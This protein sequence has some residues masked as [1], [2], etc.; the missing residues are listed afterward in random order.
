MERF[1]K[2]EFLKTA[3]K[4]GVGNVTEVYWENHLYSFCF[5]NVFRFS[6]FFKKYKLEITDNEDGCD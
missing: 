5:T 3:V 4:I 6:F 2:P 1:D